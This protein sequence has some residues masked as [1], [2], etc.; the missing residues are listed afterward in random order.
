MDA[1]SIGWAIAPVVTGL[2]FAAW[3][4]LVNVR[5]GW[6]CFLVA[7]L[8]IAAMGLLSI[9]GLED[10]ASRIWIS[11]LLGAFVGAVALIGAVE[12]LHSNEKAGRVTEAKK[13]HVN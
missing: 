8:P 6:A 5:T 1:V 11:G 10:M 12:T 9:P 4:L 2:L 3:A 7:P 13:T